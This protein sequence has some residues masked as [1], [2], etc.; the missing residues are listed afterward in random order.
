MGVV[1]GRVN[2]V[3]FAPVMDTRLSF[4]MTT[5]IFQGALRAN[6]RS[7][8][9]T[10]SA[11]SAEHTMGGMFDEPWSAGRPATMKATEL[12]Q[13]AKRFR[14]GL[15]KDREGDMMCGM[16]CYP[17]H[18]YLNFLGEHVTLE[19]VS[20]KFS[21]HVF[22][23]LESGLVLDPTA[24]QFGQS[25]V[26]LGKELWFHRNYCKESRGCEFLQAAKGGG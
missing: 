18:S 17:L 22:L 9:K 6:Q 13:I 4:L 12:K 23:R 25:K 2:L 3:D 26:Y 14:S 16:V 15:L 1:T 7:G 19:E 10:A 20:L 24:D 21:N 8:L 5:A 11:R